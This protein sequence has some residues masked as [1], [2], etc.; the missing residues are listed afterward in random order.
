MPS[1]PPSD[2]LTTSRDC[3]FLRA[4]T[5]LLRGHSRGVFYSQRILAIFEHKSLD[6]VRSNLM[7]TY[8]RFC[9]CRPLKRLLPWRQPQRL[10]VAFLHLVGSA[11]PCSAFEHG[12]N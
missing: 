9:S 6:R 1:V 12:L 5:L 11:L 4:S 10:S 3:G 8:K 2:S 7:V